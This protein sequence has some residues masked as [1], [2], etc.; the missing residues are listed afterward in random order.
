MRDRFRRARWREAVGASGTVR[1]IDTLVRAHGWGKEGITP[2]SLERLREVLLK[3]G[4]VD[5]L[6][7]DGLNPKRRPYL[8]GGAVILGVVMEA[9]GI[10]QLQ[11]SD[12]AL[13]EGLI[14]D[15]IGRI[16]DRDVRQRSVET[17]ADRA[18]YEDPCRAP[19]GETSTS[20]VRDWLYPEV[21]S[22]RLPATAGVGML[23]P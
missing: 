3:A 4:S 7:L 20:A 17:L 12:S 21:T 13:R 10:E 16:R 8:A 14:Y 6:R 15:L 5:K 9:L 22:T 11:R 2:A 19:A 1:A 23:Q 18:T